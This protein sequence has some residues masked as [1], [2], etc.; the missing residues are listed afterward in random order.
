ML[1][2]LILSV[3]I[4]GILLTITIMSFIILKIIE[5][6]QEK[7]Q[8]QWIGH[9]SFMIPNFKGAFIGIF[10]IFF[11]LIMWLVYFIIV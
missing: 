11:I 3:P 8:D 5:K 1:L 10:W 2:E 4:W 9:S 6:I 7:K